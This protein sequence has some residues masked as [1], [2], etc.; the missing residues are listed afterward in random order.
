M[1]LKENGNI[2]LFAANGKRKRQTSNCILP[3]VKRKQMFVFLGRQTINGNQHVLFHQMC[4]SMVFN[5]GP[6]KPSC[7]LFAPLK[8]KLAIR[9]F[10]H[11]TLCYFK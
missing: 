4:T 2:Y 1:E 8:A 11:Q 10:L 6:C 3:V 7:C 9:S 5:N